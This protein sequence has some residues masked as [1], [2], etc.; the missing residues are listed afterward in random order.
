MVSPAASITCAQPPISSTA[1]WPRRLMTFAPRSPASPPLMPNGFSRRGVDGVGA[2]EPA[3]GRRAGAD[4]LV[5]LVALVAKGQVV[6]RALRG[7]KRAKRAKQAVSD[8]L[9]DLDVAGGDRRRLAR[10]QHRSP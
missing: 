3:A 8:R 7:G 5:V 1:G 2:I 9:G 6:H 4:R 10:R